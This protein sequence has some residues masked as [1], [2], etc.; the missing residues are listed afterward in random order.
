MA[1]FMNLVELIPL[2]DSTHKIKR[3]HTCLV[4]FG[5]VIVLGVGT[6]AIFEVIFSDYSLGDAPVGYPIPWRS[7]QDLAFD[8]MIGLG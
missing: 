1:I 2:S 5:D 3:P 4:G 8:L 6:Y 7:K